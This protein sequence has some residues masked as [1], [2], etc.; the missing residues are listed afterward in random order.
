[1]EF[2]SLFLNGVKGCLSFEVLA[3]PIICGVIA[4]VII[5]C[6]AFFRGV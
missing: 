2:F 6:L 5:G 3:V 1:M 4:S